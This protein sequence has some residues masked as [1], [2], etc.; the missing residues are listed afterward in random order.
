MSW[1]RASRLDGKVSFGQPCRERAAGAGGP[2]RALVFAF[3]GWEIWVLASAA[4]RSL[5]FVRSPLA[6]EVSDCRGRGARAPGGGESARV[7]DATQVKKQLWKKTGS[8]APA[9]WAQC[10][11]RACVCSREE[12][13][14]G[15]GPAVPT[16]QPSAPCL[17]ASQMCHVSFLGR[18]LPPAGWL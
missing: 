5:A 4:A 16:G 13:P 8:V 9:P 17:W 3:P 2:G 12:G 14:R 15:P 10:P 11:L 6:A 18:K 7:G 1:E